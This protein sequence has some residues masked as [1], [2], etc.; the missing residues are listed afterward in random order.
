MQR[1]IEKCRNPGLEKNL[2]P[3]SSGKKKKKLARS[4]THG[5]EAAL[6]AGSHPQS[7]RDATD[8]IRVL[9]PKPTSVL[10]SWLC[11]LTPAQLG[12]RL[13]LQLGSITPPPPPVSILSKAAT[14]VVCAQASLLLLC[15]LKGIPGS[16]QHTDEQGLFLSLQAWTQSHAD[17]CIPMSVV[18]V[19]IAQHTEASQISNVRLSPTPFLGRCYEFSH[20]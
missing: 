2:Q 3:A 13:P 12:S 5:S 18:G 4:Q 8:T 20:V 1:K 9:I 14:S 17:V 19:H 16:S 10:Y 15:H 11:C 7:H 6:P